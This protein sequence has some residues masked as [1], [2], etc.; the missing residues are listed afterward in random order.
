MPNNDYILRS[1]A[2]FELY[3]NASAKDPVLVI[4]HRVDL[5]ERI[6]KIPASDVEPVRHGKW[7]PINRSNLSWGQFGIAQHK[8]SVCGGEEVIAR[9][10]CPECGAKMNEDA[11]N[12]SIQ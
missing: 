10:R 8:C 2:L 3:R 7:I 12:G 11:Y 5:C 6:E 9:K 1:E 4:S